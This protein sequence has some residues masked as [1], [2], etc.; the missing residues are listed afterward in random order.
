MQH[1]SQPTVHHPHAG[2]VQPAPRLVALL[3]SLAHEGG[4][5]GEDVVKGWS[6]GGVRVPAVSHH[7][8]HG[9]WSSPAVIK[10]ENRRFQKLT[11]SMKL[12]YEWK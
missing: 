1:V 11:F 7:P 3:V 12:F 4:Q 2:G 5:A 10:S 6:H 8:G 9:Q